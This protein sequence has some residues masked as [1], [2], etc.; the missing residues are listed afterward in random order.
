MA[1]WQPR[2]SFAFTPDGARVAYQVVGSGDRD[3]VFLTDWAHSIDLM[4][5]LPEIERFLRRLA[6]IG[7][8]ILFDKRGNGASDGRVFGS[9]DFQGVVEQSAEDLLAVLD[10]VESER[11]D[12]VASTAGGTTAVLFAATHPERCGRLVLQDACPR[13]VSSPEYPHGLDAMELQAVIEGIRSGWGKGSALAQQPDRFEDRD[14]RLWYGRYERLAVERSWMVQAWE[15]I[16]VVDVRAILASV[17]APTL[18]LVHDKAP[19]FG[20]GHG[21]YLV[22][23]MPSAEL[24]E[25]PGPGCLFWADAQIVDAAVAYLGAAKSGVVDESRV[26]ATIVMTDMVSSTLTLAEMGDHRWR[27]VLDAHDRVT[28]QL[29]TQ[30]RGRLVNRTGDGLVAT[31]DGPARGV[32]CAEAM[33]GEVG[34]LGVE[35]RAGVHVGEIELRGDEI[36]GIAVHLA[37]RVMSEADAGQVVVTRTVKDLTAGSGLSFDDMG[38]REL[39]GIPDP[40]QLLVLKH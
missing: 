8:L 38:M 19:A 4:W 30:F 23:H 34:V 5:E 2:T 6:S 14:L 7:R 24:V 10:A 12:L 27:E 33:C 1:V 37:A 26:L 3:V 18:L 32:R 22:E 28:G 35:V 39:K 11:A 29:V 40:W 15:Q 13:V 20:N 25:L 9:E 21:R 31:F 16:A 36:G 17:Q